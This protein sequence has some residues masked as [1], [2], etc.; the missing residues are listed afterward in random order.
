MSDRHA[1]AAGSAQAALAAGAEA[2]LAQNNAYG[3]SEL[4]LALGVLFFSL[5]MLRG[6]FSKWIAILGMATFGAAVIGGLLMPVLGV[7]YL[8]WW[9][10][11]FVW[12]L[13]VGRKLRR[14][15]RGAI[16]RGLSAPGGS[17]EDE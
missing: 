12:L 3:P 17:Q 13:A 7:A 9:A 14:F 11:V 10:S 6:G 4:I 2:L 1:S 15:S 5:A 8:W 16:P